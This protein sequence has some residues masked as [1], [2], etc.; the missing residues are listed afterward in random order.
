VGPKIDLD[1]KKLLTLPGLE[2]PLLGRTAHGQSL[3]RL[4]YSG[5]FSL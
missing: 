3:Y 1:D 2:L 4:N 5:S